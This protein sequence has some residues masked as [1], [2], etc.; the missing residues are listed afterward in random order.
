MTL[1]GSLRL[2]PV[3]TSTATGYYFDPM[4]LTYPARHQFT[5][6][7]GWNL[8]N[9]HTHRANNFGFLAAHDFVA[10]P[11]AI[12]VIGDSFVESS[13]LA[14]HDRFDSQLESQLKDR[15][16][17]SMGGP[18]SALLDYAERIRFASQQ[19][20][21]RDFVVLLENGDISQSICGSGNVH[22]GCVD[23]R[24][25][26]S[27][28]EK[29]APA[30]RLKQA[31]R[32]LALPQYLFSQLK[33][34]PDWLFPKT[35]LTKIRATNIETPASIAG[36]DSLTVN[37]QATQKIIDTFFERIRPNSIG[38]LVFV[39]IGQD[40]STTSQ[41]DLPRGQLAT[42]AAQ[43]AA[44]VIEAAPTLAAHATKSGLSIRVS[45]NDGHLNKSGLKLVAQQVAP[46][47]ADAAPMPR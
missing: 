38:R 39:H 23:A 12:A 45:P 9:A 3:S 30:G 42:A 37:P 29:Q 27:R 15:V 18:G 43:H 26:E 14:Q 17:Y 41:P 7:T 31:L 28:M 16:V 32:Q 40:P 34:T 10:N 6:S 25:L 5:V 19:F 46:M 2:L 13:M 22:A 21:I 36:R 47:F 33:I 1:E 24:S 8:Q 35:W 20:G 4:I 11:E 44:F